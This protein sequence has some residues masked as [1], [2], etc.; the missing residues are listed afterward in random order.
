MKQTLLGLLLFLG[1]GNVL[2]GQ[3]YQAAGS[4]HVPRTDHQSQLLNDGTVLTFGG[5]NGYMQTPYYYRSAELYTRSSNTWAYTDSM[6]MPRTFFASAILNDG[7][8]MA[9]GGSNADSA[10][11]A[12]CEWYDPATGK[13]STAP[14]LNSPR[15]SHK[16]VTLYN[17]NILV[18]GGFDYSCEIF[19]VSLNKWIM[20]PPSIYKHGAGSAV[21]LLSNGT[22]LICGGDL[23]PQ[24]AEIYDPFR[25]VWNMISSLN[26]A[27]TYSTAVELKDGRILV[28]GSTKLNYQNTSE[29]YNPATNTFPTT[30]LL[31]ANRASDPGILLDDGRVLTYGIG[32]ITNANTKVI[33]IFDPANNTWT[34][35]TYNFLGSNA[36]TLTKLFSGELLITAG[37]T[38][39]GN[40][41]NVSCLLINA[42]SDANCVPPSTSLL[43]SASPLNACIGKDIIVT[44]PS[45][46]AGVSYR[47]MINSIPVG[48]TVN[49][50]G[51]I[52]LTLP[53]GILVPGKNVIRITASK[54]GCSSV[55]LTNTI[56]INLTEGNGVKPHIVSNGSLTFCEDVTGVTLSPAVSSSG[57]LWS[58][59]ETTASIQPKKTGNYFFRSVDATGCL[60]ATSDTVFVKVLNPKFDIYLKDT[61]R[62]FCSNQAPEQLKVSPPYGNWTGPGVTPE[63]LFD[64]SKL[65]D[66]V[67]TIQYNYCHKSARIKITIT[68][69]PATTAFTIQT[70]KKKICKGQTVTITPKGATFPA[71]Y[72]L[73][74]NDVKTGNTLTNGA[75]SWSIPLTSTSYLKIVETQTNNCGKTV[76]T[77]YDTIQMYPEPLINLSATIDTT[78]RNL[79][80]NVKIEN[81]EAGYKYVA[82]INNIRASDTLIGNGGLLILPLKNGSDGNIITIKVIGPGGCMRILTASPKINFRYI[83]LN[84]TTSFKGGLV[85]ESFIIL[86]QSNADSY[87]W[88]I[89]GNSSTKFN[90]DPFSF[91]STGMKKIT[92][93]SDSRIENCKDTLTKYVEIV[94]APGKAPGSACEY[95]TLKQ[96]PMSLSQSNQMMAYHVDKDGNKYFSQ[97]M[98]YKDGANYYGSYGLILKKFDKNNN[99][100]WEKRHNPWEG[101]YSAVDFACNYVIDIESDNSGNIYIAGR[102]HGN[103]WKWDNMEIKFNDVGP[104][105]YLLKLNAAGIV[106]WYIY[107]QSS[108]AGNSLPSFTDI[109]Y[110]NDN[111]I[112]AAVAYPKTMFFPDG[113][114]SNFDRC[115]IN[116]I[117]INKDGKLLK[118]FSSDP[119][120]N[121]GIL[122][123]SYNPDPAAEVLMRN[124]GVAP[125]MSLCANGKLILSGKSTNGS[126]YFNGE[127]YKTTSNFTTF[128]A[129][130]NTGTGW[131][132]V[133]PLYDSDSRT[134][135]SWGPV[136][137][138]TFL[139]T[140]AS[141]NIYISDF[142]SRASSMMTVFINSDIKKIQDQGGF[143]AKF[144]SNGKLI[145]YN[146]TTY[147]TLRGTVQLSNEILV[148]GDYMDFYSSGAVNHVGRR[149]KGV[150][151]Q[152]LTSYDLSGKI[153]WVE[154]ISGDTNDLSFCMTKDLCSDNVYFC[155]R[156]ISTSTFMNRSLTLKTFTATVGKYTGSGDCNV[157]G[158]S[159]DCAGIT[160]GAA[161]IDSCRTCAG[162][163]TGVTPVLNPK[164]CITTSITD[165]ADGAE[166]MVYPNPT[167]GTLTIKTTDAILATTII[168]AVGKVVLSFTTATG[169][170]EWSTDISELPSAIYFIHVK[171]SKTDFYRKVLVVK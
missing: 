142:F 126:L 74:V 67:Y 22:V 84:Y 17:G 122:L 129:I 119:P 105:A 159:K 4:L 30:G 12:A 118:K 80:P 97:S 7:R 78:C 52:N 75:P 56:T 34:T 169:T 60:S 83:T 89:D 28:Y 135:S 143:T 1:L 16:A 41:A 152:I 127:T 125:R 151:D 51:S 26:Y 148:Y 136:A 49:G 106:Q 38:T 121:T 36:Y 25:N 156:S 116:V 149:C 102:F 163:N 50:G 21:T 150:K 70:D 167:S 14:A 107:S 64:P 117:T 11:L 158:C 68:T 115:A 63:G 77:K 37:M 141:N 72:E 71:S 46:E 134:P 76:T 65:T 24:Y 132:K 161:F 73:Y 5:F 157:T 166:L 130:L 145:W 95:D 62:S 39:T 53:S 66:G 120:I 154:G 86:N 8:V 88:N 147:I 55:T 101:S 96:T 100:L 48:T 144:D 69:P 99:L 170:N 2:T 79:L 57:Y 10:A 133:F 44:I 104:V 19:D 85:G 98:R 23:A 27:R 92:L 61:L 13:W 103:Y 160:N 109:I 43:V 20:G 146:P 114:Q 128:A 131:E 155:G 94:D 45:S 124:A 31:N 58:S 139:T 18:L 3:T 140:D 15:S 81:S 87:I 137:S 153:N 111:T 123:T 32:D 171:T 40:G 138:T 91:S 6:K 54:N 82:F 47:A 168:N 110:V 33:E 113:T 165:L 90:P 59:G 9:I 162:G 112:Y 29:I 108:Y 35:K 93:F 164:L 42:S